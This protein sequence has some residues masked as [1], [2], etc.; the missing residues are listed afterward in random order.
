MYKAAETVRELLPAFFAAAGIGHGASAFDD[1]E[2]LIFA[3]DQEFFAIEL[4]LGGAVL[5]EKHALTRA[6]I[7][8]LSDAIC[9][10]LAFADRHDFTLLRPLS[11]GVGDDDTAARLLA[12][13]NPS[14]DHTDR[15]GV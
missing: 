4:D 3:H 7:E 8:R 10:V 6:D 14:H 15:A 9:A 11:S 1:A 5:A 13:C 2:D 12:L